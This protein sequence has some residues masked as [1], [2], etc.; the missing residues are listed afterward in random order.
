M[1]DKDLVIANLEREA[2]ENRATIKRLEIKLILVNED[3]QEA[4]A[5]NGSRELIS[6]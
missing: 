3:L 6:S 2:K 1:E 4:L 5:R